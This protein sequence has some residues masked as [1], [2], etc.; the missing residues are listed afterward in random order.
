[1]YRTM[2]WQIDELVLLVGYF[3]ALLAAGE[4]AFRL[5][6]RQVGRVAESDREHL[7]ALQSAALGLLGLLLGFTFFMG[8][9]RF[10]TRKSLVVD[11]ANAIGTAY[12]RADVLPPEPRANARRLI[13]A[14]VSARLEFYAAGIDSARIARSNADAARIEATLWTIAAAAGA[15]D[16]R[17]VL[18]GLFAQSLNDV[19][20][21]REKRQ[22]ALD[23][24]VPDAVLLLLLVVS[25][26]SHGLIGYGCGLAARRR[27]VPNALFALLVALVFTTI[28]DIDRPRRGL[29]EV[30]QDSLIRL[31]AALERD[32]P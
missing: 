23:N 20:D 30:S 32:S 22:V 2:F 11:E 17:S 25:I 7:G 26:A 24:H 27:L 28:L 13:R 21:I 12:L 18:A 31:K 15:Q 4:A 8:V 5:G 19:F 3:C 1:M 6:R 9:S 29:I 10:D 16:P 14:H